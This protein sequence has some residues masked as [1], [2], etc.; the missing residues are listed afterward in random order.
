MKTKPADPVDPTIPRP[1]TPLPEAA[2]PAVVDERLERI[3]TLWQRCNGYVQFICAADQRGGS[4]VELKDKAL[5]ALCAR[6]VII[7]RQLSRIQ[8]DLQLG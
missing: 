6:L 8:D 2:A 1:T 7:E 5:D 3:G 4:S